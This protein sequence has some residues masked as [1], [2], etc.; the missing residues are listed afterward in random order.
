MWRWL[1]VEP[2]SVDNGGNVLRRRSS[3]NDF[4]LQLNCWFVV[5]Y[6]SF[7]NYRTAEYLPVDRTNLLWQ[8]F[9]VVYNSHHLFYLWNNLSF[10]SV[11]KVLVPWVKYARLSLTIKLIINFI[12]RNSQSTQF[13]FKLN[14][15]SLTIPRD[16]LYKHPYHHYKR[17]I[18]CNL[19]ALPADCHTGENLFP[20]QDYV[21]R[22]LVDSRELSCSSVY[23]DK[24]TII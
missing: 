12:A 17:R 24:F 9:A 15:L 11:N 20:R 19:T 6:A 10:I 4:L 5:W 21:P 3:K 7:L 13:V 14:F 1:S 22:L 16:F 18:A 23:I 8:V 2:T